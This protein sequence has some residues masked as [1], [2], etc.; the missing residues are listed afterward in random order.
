P[1]S[2]ALNI[3]GVDVTS[4]VTANLG[5]RGRARCDHG[6][7]AGH[8]LE[9]RK[10]KALVKGW[11]NK[12]ARQ[13]VDLRKLINLHVIQDGYTAAELLSN[14]SVA[15]TPPARPDQHQ[16][17]LAADL[18]RQF[19]VRPNKPLEVFP[20]LSRPHKQNEIFRQA[21]LAL[22]GFQCFF[23]INLKHVV[24]HAEM[25][26]RDH[27][28]R[29]TEKVDGF[30]LGITRVRNDFCRTSNV[31]KKVFRKVATPLFGLRFRK[32]LDGKV[33]DRCH[34]SFRFDVQRYKVQLKIKIEFGRMILGNSS[35]KS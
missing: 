25:D 17:E 28:S 15:F 27:L 18:L 20:R 35:S 12:D 13:I 26:R 23:R 30:S 16:T 19:R 1:F 2:N 31:S 24:I 33:M 8:R 6:T 21:E 32:Q 11:I 3:F 5:Q 7:T 10:S 34:D 9:R 29:N 22:A 4:R 14:R